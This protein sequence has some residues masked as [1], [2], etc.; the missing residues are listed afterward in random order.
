MAGGKTHT[1]TLG[2]QT[3]EFTE[4]DL[5]VK[6]V[7]KEGYAAESGERV[8]CV[9]DTAL[10]PEL[11]REG[12]VREIVSKVQAMRKDAG[13]SVTDHI[14]LTV[15]GDAEI[16]AAVRAFADKLQ[17]AVL[18][19]TLQYGTEGTKTD[20]NGKTCTLAVKKI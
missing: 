18:A 14:A 2:G 10:T 6:V 13:F 11:V 15:G 4:S 9:L 3:V 5:L 20:V 8:T 7:S 17:A 16:E 19:D 1:V 12:Y